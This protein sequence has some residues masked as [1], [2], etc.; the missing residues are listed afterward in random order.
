MQPASQAIQSP[1]GKRTTRA[2]RSRIGH[3]FLFDPASGRRISLPDGWQ[4]Y[5]HHQ[6]VWL[7]SS[8][9]EQ[10]FLLV[11]KAFPDR[12]RLPT[13]LAEGDLDLYLVSIGEERQLQAP[14]RCLPVAGALSGKD[15]RGV[16]ALV[17]LNNG[18]HYLVLLAT[19]SGDL[20]TDL[21]AML[22]RL[23]MAMIS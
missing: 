16:L 12:R 10:V 5:Q 17:A 14:I 6:R 13:I 11:E 9:D 4:I 22:I 19:E 2:P 20:D 15:I 21:E 23:G 1:S 8:A 7:G 18:D 3:R